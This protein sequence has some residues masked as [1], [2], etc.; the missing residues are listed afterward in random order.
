MNETREAAPGDFI[1]E[2]AAERGDEAREEHGEHGHPGA[3]EYVMV[4]FVLAFITAVEVAIYYIDLN[5][6]TLVVSLLALSA[7]K[8]SMVAAFFMHLKFDTRVFT[9]FFAGG[10]AMAVAAFIAV[11]SMFRAF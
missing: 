10:L 6:T 1:S 3:G 4:A 2:R 9:T 7:V 11:L 8:F 5:R